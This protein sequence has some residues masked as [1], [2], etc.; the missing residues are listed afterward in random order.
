MYFLYSKL[1]FALY[2]C[3]AMLCRYSHS[4]FNFLSHFP[5]HPFSNHPRIAETKGASWAESSLSISWAAATSFSFY[6]MIWLKTCGLFDFECVVECD[7]T[8]LIMCGTF[9]VDFT[10]L[11]QFQYEQQQHSNTDHSMTALVIIQLSSLSLEVWVYGQQ[12]SLTVSYTHLT[13][14]TNREV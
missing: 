9:L 14:P 13:L 10:D 7:C 11:F 2:H 12:W 5:A 3:V 1:I 6:V 4:P 8:W